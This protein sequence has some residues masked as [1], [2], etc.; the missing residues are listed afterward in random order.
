MS[1]LLLSNLSRYKDTKVFSEGGIVEF[2][3]FEA[4]NE[5]VEARTDF[6]IHRVKQNEVGFLDLLAV[7]Y[8][9]RGY[10]TLWW[11]IALA[12]ALIDPE[13]E[14]FPGM[15]LVIPPRDAVVL[16]L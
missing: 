3:L 6:K 14:M 10:E 13:T 15:T 5:F 9:G 8:Y 7:R 4:P 16:F 12:N 1:N 11:V 2:A